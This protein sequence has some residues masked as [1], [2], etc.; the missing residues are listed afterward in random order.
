MTFAVRCPN[1]NSAKTK[2]VAS[3]QQDPI[4]FIRSRKCLACEHKWY[5]RQGKEEV[6]QKYDII[7]IRVCGKTTRAVLKENFQPQ[8][9]NGS[10]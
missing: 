9:E 8:S 4:Y 10:P 3:Y 1:C 5:S 7:W 6:I 2:V